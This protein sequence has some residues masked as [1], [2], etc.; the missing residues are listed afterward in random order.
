M[1][2]RYD[3]IL[4]RAII[5]IETLNNLSCSISKEGRLHIIPCTGYRIELIGLPE[6]GKYLVFL[7][8]EWREINQ[9]Y[10]RGT[11]DVP[12][13]DANPQAIA[14]SLFPPRTKNELIFG[15]IGVLVTLFPDIRAY[16]D[17]VIFKFVR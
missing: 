6:T 14:L 4:A 10:D 9:D 12:V 2:L 17:I 15:K 16:Q 8:K 11:I 3:L 1:K 5:F 13:T 7:R